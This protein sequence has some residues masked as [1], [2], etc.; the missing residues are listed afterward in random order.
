LR[1]AAREPS[2]LAIGVDTNASGLVEVSRRAH[3]KGLGN[4]VF[5]AGE[6]T[7]ALLLLC[8]QVDA[9]TITLP[10][11]SLLQRVLEGER[12]FALAVAGAL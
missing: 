7:E 8:G 5:F 10:W 9:I 12:A 2:T 11:G 6:A 1:L 4:A 3:K